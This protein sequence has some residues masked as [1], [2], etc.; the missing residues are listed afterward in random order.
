MCKL[1]AING[2][3]ISIVEPFSYLENYYYHKSSGYSVVAQ[4]LLDCNKRFID[5]FVGLLGSVN[6][7]RVLNRFA[8][9]R[10]AQYHGLFESNNASS[11]HCFTPYL[12]GDKGY[13]LLLGLWPSLRK[14]DNIKFWNCC[15]LGSRKHKWSCFVVENAFNILKKT[16]SEFLT[17]F[18]L[19]VSLC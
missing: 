18:N 19:H 9:Y 10:N 12:L 13:P 3:F 16:F 7:S 1:G 8:H 6:D 11:Q 5:V 2:T 15:I 14:K 17:E 4:T